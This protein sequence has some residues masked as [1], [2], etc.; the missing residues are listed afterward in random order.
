VLKSFAVHDNE[1]VEAAINQNVEDVLI[2][3]GA[4]A[5]DPDLK[6]IAV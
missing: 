2:V 1:R 6:G 4:Q 3:E 5:F